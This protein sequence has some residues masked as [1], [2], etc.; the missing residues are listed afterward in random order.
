MM[1]QLWTLPLLIL[2]TGC[3]AGAI[4]GACLSA[5]GGTRQQSSTLALLGAILCTSYLLG[6]APQ[7]IGICSAAPTAILS[8]SCKIVESLSMSVAGVLL[9]WLTIELPFQWVMHARTL[10]YQFVIA[11]LRLL[12]Y[13]FALGVLLPRV[14]ESWL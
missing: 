10:K 3:F 13:L 7:L 5:V 11:P 14:V 8:A 4:G 1:L 12:F 2:L 6:N 9:V